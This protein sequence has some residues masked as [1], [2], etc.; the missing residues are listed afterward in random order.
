MIPVNTHRKRITAIT[1]VTNLSL[2]GVYFL[3]FLFSQTADLTQ[4]P[5]IQSVEHVQ[6]LEAIPETSCSSEARPLEECV[7]I[8]ADPQ[9]S[10]QGRREV[11][12]WWVKRL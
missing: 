11:V 12:F 9:V 3:I 8:L 1:I 6:T 2:S 7:A 5:S 4:P 10:C